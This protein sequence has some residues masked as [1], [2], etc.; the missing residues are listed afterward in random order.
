MLTEVQLGS[1]HSRDRDV[2]EYIKKLK[3]STSNFTVIDIGASANSWCEHV[4]AAIDIVD[5]SKGNIPCFTG[6]INLF[7]VWSAVID[8]VNTHGKFDFSI[9]SHTLEDISNPPLV[10]QMLPKIAKR[11][12]ISMPSKYIECKRVG[13]MT[14]CRGWLHHRWIYNYEEGKVV[15]YPKLPFTEYLESL[16]KV[17]TQGS[18]EELSFYWEDICDI[19]IVNNDYFPSEIAAIEMYSR[20]VD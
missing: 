5:L 13:A 7:E 14:G 12:F 20:L 18:S 3:E 10:A 8:Y 16:D 1:I 2:N 19:E 15:G 6:N 4:T 17:A 11:G 9:C